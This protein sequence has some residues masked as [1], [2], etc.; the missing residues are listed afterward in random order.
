M[1]GHPHNIPIVK[2]TTTPAKIPV[3]APQKTPPLFFYSLRATQFKSYS[4]L[5]LID[6]KI[7]KKRAA[8]FGTALNVFIILL[9]LL[10]LF[11]QVLLILCYEHLLLLHL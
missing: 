10:L 8:P 5:I 7:H 4:E 11:Q 6:K 1:Q 3:R 2:E 9:T